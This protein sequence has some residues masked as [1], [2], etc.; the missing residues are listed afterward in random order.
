MGYRDINEKYRKMFDKGL[1]QI[2][3]DKV[4]TLKK[5]ENSK[6]KIE[7]KKEKKPS[8]EE[9]IRLVERI[10]VTNGKSHLTRQLKDRLMKL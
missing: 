3:E 6:K 10:E 7:E 9:L 4:E 8:K 2:K 1:K 5:F